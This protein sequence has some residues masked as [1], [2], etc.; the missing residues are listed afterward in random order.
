MESVKTIQIPEGYV[1]DTEQS[2]E[3]QIV[4]KKN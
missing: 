3:R 1:I 2:N 4:L